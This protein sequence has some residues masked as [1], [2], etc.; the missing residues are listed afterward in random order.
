MYDRLF[1]H[2]HPLWSLC[3]LIIRKKSKSKKLKCLSL[4]PLESSRAL[5]EASGSQP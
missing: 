4:L 3:S 2:L 5:Y 1:A